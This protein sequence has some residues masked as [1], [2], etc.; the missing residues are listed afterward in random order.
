MRMRLIR[1]VSIPCISLLAVGAAACAAPSG[2]SGPAATQLEITTLQ[3][4][5]GGT[6]PPPGQP[7]CRTN[8]ASRNV[9]VSAS[10]QVVAVGRSN[11]AGKLV[12]AVPARQLTVAILDAEFYED[13]DA[14]TVFALAAQTVPVTQ[15]CRFNAP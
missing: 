11:S 7:F 3:T 1:L 8:P 12:I 13:C 10:R 5:C 2:P 4:I 6:I 14:P 9:Q 15:T